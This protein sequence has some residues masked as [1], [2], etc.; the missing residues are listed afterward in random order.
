MAF[1][2][3]KRSLTCKHKTLLPY[4]SPLDGWGY[5][6][7]TPTNLA[8]YSG[9]RFS[10]IAVLLLFAI[11]LT[12]FTPAVLPSPPTPLT[13][14]PYLKLFCHLRCKVL[15]QVFYR[16]FWQQVHPAVVE[17]AVDD[18][19]AQGICPLQGSLLLLCAN[20][21]ADV[22]PWNLIWPPH[23]PHLFLTPAGLSSSCR[24]GG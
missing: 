16:E 13:D 3:R 10:H 11:Q 6:I 22:G 17:V 18:N 2:I 19:A 24:K 8:R 14:R 5:F 9:K 4:F 21:T 20:V 23:G 12:N 15:L 7:V 1:P